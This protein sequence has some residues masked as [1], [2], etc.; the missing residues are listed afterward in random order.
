[1]TI[2]GISHITLIVQDLERTGSFLTSVMGAK[3]IYS[4]GERKF[5]LSKEKLFLL[6]GTW[7]AIMEGQPLSER[8]YNHIA[9]KISEAEFE[10][11][12]QRLKNARVEFREQRPR[13]QGEGVSLYF[14]DYDNHLF[15]RCRNGQPD[16]PPRPPRYW[17]ARPC[18]PAESWRRAV[19][20]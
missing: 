1:M 20:K 5:S 10:E 4:S 2:E 12:R 6:A 3:E 15:D 11:Y 17:P 7:I 18:N 8:S 14:Y 9:F 13:V 16:R 19:G